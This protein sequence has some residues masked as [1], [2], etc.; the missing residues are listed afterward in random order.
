M[1]LPRRILVLTKATGLEPRRINNGLCNAIADILTEIYPHLEYQT[2]SQWDI[3]GITGHHWVY[4]PKTGLHHDVETPH[5]VPH[6][7]NLPFFQRH[8]QG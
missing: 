1:N 4:D 6:P 7:I 8:L 5:G 2:A 3:N